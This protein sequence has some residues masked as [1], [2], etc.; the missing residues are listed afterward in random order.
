MRLEAGADQDE[1]VGLEELPEVDVGQGPRVRRIACTL[2]AIEIQ[3]GE[4]V[5]GRDLVVDED[6]RRAR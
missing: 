3:R 2:E 1:V 6:A 4:R 5:H